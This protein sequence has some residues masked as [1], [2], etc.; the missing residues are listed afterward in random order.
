MTRSDRRRMAARRQS[1]ISV[2]RHAQTKCFPG[3][4]RIQPIG[5]VLACSV[6]C[7]P[8]PHR[9]E[10]LFR[11]PFR[12]IYVRLSDLLEQLSAHRDQLLS[13]GGTLLQHFFYPFW[14]SNFLSFYFPSFSFHSP[15][16]RPVIA[17]RVSRGALLSRR[18]CFGTRTCPKVGQN[19]GRVLQTDSRSIQ[20]QY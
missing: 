4:T 11:L 16:V 2:H 20:P 3:A 9:Q 19:A 10:C 17:V 5:L 6:R 1:N 18:E 8:L 7:K 13:F 15:Q 12:T 14:I